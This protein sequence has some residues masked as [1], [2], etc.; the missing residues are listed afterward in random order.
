LEKEGRHHDDRTNFPI[1]ASHLTNHELAGQKQHHFGASLQCRRVVVALGSQ[2][3]S[4]TTTPDFPRHFQIRPVI[5]PITECWE[6]RT[7]G[8]GQRSG[9]SM[10][11]DQPA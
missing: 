7:V 3:F 8:S 5:D 10:I 1:V 9:S 4:P 2:A 6:D 11:Q